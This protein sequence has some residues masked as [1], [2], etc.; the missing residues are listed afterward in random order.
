MAASSFEA[1]LAK[2]TIEAYVRDAKILEI[3]GD[4]PDNLKAPAG[5]FVSL[6]I[7]GC[8][9]GCIGTIEPQQ[10]SVA[11]EIIQNAISA[12]VSDPR[13]LPVAPHEL[14]SISY[15]VDILSA[16]EPVESPDELDPKAFGAIV[17]AGGRR[18]LLL[19]DIEGVETV[20]QQ[21]AICRQ[22][23]GIGEREEVRLCRF[24]VTR[25]V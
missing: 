12:A 13:F 25:Y 18:G 20:Q 14:D 19:P 9:R 1:Q 23:A 2:R 21:I 5:V 11:A 16:P 22:K 7:G 10:E 4:V 24:T 17:E 3:P 8:L 6:K 15:S